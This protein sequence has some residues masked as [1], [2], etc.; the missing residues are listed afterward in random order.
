MFELYSEYKNE[1]LN[2]TIRRLNITGLSLKRDEKIERIHEEYSDIELLSYLLYDYELEFLKK[3]LNKK[4]IETNYITYQL[5]KLLIL[6]DVNGRLKVNDYIKE[7]LSQGLEYYR[8]TKVESDNTK[9]LVYF[10]IGYVRYRGIVSSKDLYNAFHESFHLNKKQI[11]DVMFLMKEHPLFNRFIKSK[12]I[13][14]KLYYYLIEFGYEDFEVVEYQHE[15]YEF[16]LSSE[17]IINI[18]KYYLDIESDEYKSAINNLGN[19]IYLSKV[20]RA[21]LI[22]ISG[23][24]AFEYYNSFHVIDVNTKRLLNLDTNTDIL[25]YLEILPSFYPIGKTSIFLDSSKIKDMFKAY[26]AAMYFKFK[27]KFG[28]DQKPMFIEKGHVVD[29]TKLQGLINAHKDDIEKISKNTPKDYYVYKFLDGKVILLDI[30]L[31]ELVF[32]KTNIYSFIINSR[33]LGKVVNQNLVNVDGNLTPIINN[34][35]HA[36]DESVEEEYISICE[37]LMKN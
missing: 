20:D 16:N 22:Y 2:D 11:D 37:K 35:I 30:E 26:I 6:V 17:K 7:Y 4:N 1:F 13:N 14:S 23:F 27:D 34:Y 28:S 9:Y 36:I 24:A 32:M 10:A 3:N 15:N 8:Q 12:K 33:A 31:K 19:A 18:G 29:E 25:D 21:E 5:E